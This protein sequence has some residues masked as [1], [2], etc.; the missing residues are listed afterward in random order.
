MEKL[1]RVKFFLFFLLFSSVLFADVSQRVENT[2]FIV[3]QENPYDYDRVRLRL[4]YSDDAYFAT[5]IGDGVNYIGKNY[6]NSLEYSYKKS[7]QS[8]TPFGTQTNAYNYT[9]GQSYA[10]IY[11]AYGGYDDGNNRVVI[12]LQNISMGVGRIWTPTNLFN[13]RNIYALEPDETFGVLALAYTRQLNDTSDIAVI[14][15]QKRDSSFK[16]AGRYKAYLDF[17]DVGLDA[18]Y[19]DKTKML[20]YEI[21]GNLLNTGVELRSESAYIKN[22]NKQNKEDG[23]FQGIIGGDYAFV[24]GVTLTTEALYSS[25][26]FTPEQTVTH[27]HSDIVANMVSSHFYGATSLTYSFNIFLD[28]SLLYID[29]LK[30]TNTRFISPSLTYTFN[31]Y[32]SFLLGSIIE[33]YKKSYYLKWRLSF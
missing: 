14:V 27:L 13:P 20:G 18:I 19:S 7:L 8:D 2:N 16:Y 17:A 31:D 11:R 22:K 30:G 24:D 9:S 3:S 25:K 26:T 28:A 10:K 29:G 15:S 12:G 4:D 5:F 6:L 21:E 32:N 1:L 23:F 33:G